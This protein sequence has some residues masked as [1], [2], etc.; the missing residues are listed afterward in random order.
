MHPVAPA[1]RSSWAHL[2][3]LAPCGSLQ[4]AA[5]GRKSDAWYRNP[6][7]F[8]GSVYRVYQP[9][10]QVFAGDK[11]KSSK[12]PREKVGEKC[13]A[14]MVV[15]H[16]ATPPEKKKNGQRKKKR[17]LWTRSFEWST[18][19]SGTQIQTPSPVKIATAAWTAR[20]DWVKEA[21]GRPGEILGAHLGTAP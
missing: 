15:N 20:K 10:T 8:F 13:L 17:Y 5:T 1:R 6:R 2:G 21:N 14:A 9:Y 19:V 7:F 16:Q 12:I 3:A 4:L 11:K 18:S